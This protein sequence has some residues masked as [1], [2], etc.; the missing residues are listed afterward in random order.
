MQVAN[1]VIFWGFPV[2]TAGFPLPSGRGQADGA[3]AA[4]CLASR[5][6]VVQEGLGSL[7]R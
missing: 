6:C 5:S 2:D 3:V 4:Y 1:L 7:A